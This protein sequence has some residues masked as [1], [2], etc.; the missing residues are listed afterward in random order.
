MSKI[1]WHD[2][3][4]VFPKPNQE[5]LVMHSFDH[6]ISNSTYITS[7]DGDHY[8]DNRKDLV[9]Q[10]SEVDYWAELQRP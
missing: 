2:A 4:K 10:A 9:L 8:W 3:Q 5:V 1:E 6:N 7:S